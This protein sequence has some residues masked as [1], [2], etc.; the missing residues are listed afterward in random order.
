MVS[1]V[2]GLETGRMEVQGTEK[3]NETRSTDLKRGRKFCRYEENLKLY[4]QGKRF[5]K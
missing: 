2:P 4:D 1:E 3:G 5:Y